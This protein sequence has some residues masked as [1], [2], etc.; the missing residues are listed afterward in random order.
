M[1]YFLLIKVPK[2]GENHY[3]TVSP[4]NEYK[5]KNFGTKG[6][7]WLTMMFYLSGMVDSIT[8]IVCTKLESSTG[9]LAGRAAGTR[10]IENHSN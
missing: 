2:S 3:F 10:K 1:T 6:I 9:T 8:S 5:L 4:E 7:F